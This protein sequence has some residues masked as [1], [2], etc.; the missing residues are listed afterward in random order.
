MS[1]GIIRIA[2]WS[3]PRNISTAMMRAWENRNDTVVVDEPLYGPYLATTNKQHAMYQEII[4]HQ[5]SDW[6]PIV[7]Y[8]TEHIPMMSRVPTPSSDLEVTLNTSQNIFDSHANRV[9]TSQHMPVHIFYQKHM[10]HH[11]TEDVSLDFVDHL[12][13]AFLIRHPNDVLS[14]YL[15]K[16]PRATPSDLGYPQQ[17]ELFNRVKQNS[18]QVPPVFESKDILMKPQDML[19]KMCKALG[20]AFDENMLNWPKGYRDSDGIWAPHWYNRV[21]ESTGFAAYKPKEN[22]LSKAEQEIADACMP[23][24]EA[25]MTHKIS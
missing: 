6:R 20:V 7:K 12:R 13:N 24:Y 14:S 8:L 16:H 3:G 23:Y 17:L 21:I 9:N 5:G 22:K 10:S 25:L 19:T 1:D 15:R 2:M 4:K 18:G 11:I